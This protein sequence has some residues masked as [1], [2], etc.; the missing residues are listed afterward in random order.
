MTS[1]FARIASRLQEIII[2]LG[3][4]EQDEAMLNGYAA[5]VL[6]MGENVTLKAINAIW[7]M[8][9]VIEGWSY[10][11]A[12]DKDARLSPY[13]VPFERLSAEIVAYDE[14]FLAAV[15]QV[16]REYREHPERFAV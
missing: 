5:L 14:P 15:V 4:G 9:R 11:P 2:E 7:A 12:K 10:A 13:L 6:A 8:V 3:H 1:Y 16:A